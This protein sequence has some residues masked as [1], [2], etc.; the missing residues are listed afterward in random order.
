MSNHE[1]T[2]HATDGSLWRWNSF[3]SELQRVREPA[4]PP[5]G[6]VPDNTS[7]QPEWAEIVALFERH[8]LQPPPVRLR[9][10][11]V[12][13]LTWARYGQALADQMTKAGT[14]P[15]G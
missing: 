6:R 3:R 10:E 7:G 4:E 11:L 14:E 15:N 9:D 8:R 2:F 5:I 13:L 1:P 12:S